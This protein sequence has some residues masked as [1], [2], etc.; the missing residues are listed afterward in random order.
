M[1]EGEGFE[2]PV[3]FPVQRFSRPPVST[4][5]TSLRSLAI[6]LPQDWF[7]AVGPLTS[8]SFQIRVITIITFP[9]E[10]V[11]TASSRATGPTSANA[12]SRP[13]LNSSVAK[14]GL[15]HA[16]NVSFHKVT[17]KRRTTC[18]TETAA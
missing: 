3:R 17:S 6:R 18:A 10:A 9:A 14:Q 7:D 16:I 4:A 13:Q 5:H 15:N 1:A 11:R 8:R 2:P 12:Q